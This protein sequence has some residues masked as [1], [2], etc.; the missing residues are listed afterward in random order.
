MNAPNREETHTDKEIWEA[1]EK[2]T[3]LDRLLVVIIGWVV[4]VAIGWLIGY[5]MSGI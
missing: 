1:L 4:G 2:R 5:F 3:K